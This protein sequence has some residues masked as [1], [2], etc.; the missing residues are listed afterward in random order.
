[1]TK[2]KFWSA[3]THLQGVFYI[4]FNQSFLAAVRGLAR[5]IYIGHI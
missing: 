3:I 1:M 2:V 4:L 5:K